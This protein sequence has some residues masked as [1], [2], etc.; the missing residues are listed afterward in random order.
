MPVIQATSAEVAEKYA[1]QIAKASAYVRARQL[2]Y[3]ENFTKR[4]I[5]LVESANGIL[6]GWNGKK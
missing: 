5:K 3:K 6:A 4:G 2:I 1:E